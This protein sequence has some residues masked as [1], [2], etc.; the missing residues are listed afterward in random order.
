[1]ACEHLPQPNVWKVYD[2]E[3]GFPL[4]GSDVCNV[5]CDCLLIFLE[6]YG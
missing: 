6:I 4:K 2:V 5:S 1:M 3:V